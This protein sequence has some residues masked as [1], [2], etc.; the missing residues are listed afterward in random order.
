MMKLRNPKHANQV[1][2]FK[3]FGAIWI[4]NIIT[5]IPFLIRTFGTVFFGDE[6]FPDW[7]FV[8]AYLSTISY[9]VVHPIIEASFIPECKNTI[10]F[11]IVKATCKG[12][13]LN[14]N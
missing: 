11:L 8:F 9:A 3:V 1:R 14:K 10:V 5:W 6:A 4:A 7:F 12:R 2:L 13:Y